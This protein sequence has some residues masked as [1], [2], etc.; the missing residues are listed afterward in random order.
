MNPL[1][2]S[3]GASAIWLGIGAVFYAGAF[4][5][6][7]KR[8][9]R[10]KDTPQ[11][12]FYALL[13]LGFL[14]QSAG[15][16]LRGLETRTLPLADAFELLQAIAWFAVLIE[17]GLRFFYHVRLLRLF[18][19]GF[20]AILGALSWAFYEPAVAGGGLPATGDPWLGLHVGLAI[21]SYAVFAVTA[22]SGAMYLIQQRALSAKSGGEF[23]R[24]LPPLR[25][26]DMLSGW[27]LP[28]GL[29]ALG[30]SLALGFACWWRLP[31]GEHVTFLKLALTTLVWAGFLA[32]FCLRRFSRMS[33][34]GAARACVV[35]F[36]VALASLWAIDRDR[37][38][39]MTQTED[40][41]G[42]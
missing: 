8:A 19:S 11:V 5:Y 40:V 14:C 23:F 22:L 38:I 26:L 7:L 27:L 20:A 37:Q 39:H 33:A 13:G 15:L 28:V 2:T 1:A 12:F 30:V 32:V 16:Y 21:F 25:V 3:A 36:L 29:C 34:G 6:A 31:A 35:L 4:L 41:R 9:F 42:S 10:D 17:L 24:L 18:A